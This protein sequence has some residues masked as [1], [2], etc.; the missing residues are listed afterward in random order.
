MEVPILAMSV[1]TDMRRTCT[2]RLC[3]R[4]GAA[5]LLDEMRLGDDLIPAFKNDRSKFS[6]RGA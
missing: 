5:A 6:L 2:L 4:F 1:W 3:E